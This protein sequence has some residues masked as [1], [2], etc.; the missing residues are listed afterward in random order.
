MP[1]R[2]QLPTTAVEAWKASPQARVWVGG[3][4]TSARREVEL[5]VGDS[6]RPPTGPLDQAFLTPLS[7]D[8]ALH[9]ARKLAARVVA[10]G[11]LWIVTPK[12]GSA[13]EAEFIG[14]RDEL[15]VGLFELGFVEA[16]AA[17]VSDDYTSTRFQP[18][19]SNALI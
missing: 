7:N 8:E 13:R 14:S 2:D 1:Q 4:N 16:G 18:D 15:V 12:R 11:S 3:N 5:I 19:P 17:A 9:F 10:G 6:A